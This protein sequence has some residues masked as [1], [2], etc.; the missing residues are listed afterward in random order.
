MLFRLLTALLIVEC[1]SEKAEVRVS[2]SASDT[3]PS[4]LM[5]HPRVAENCKE[6][7]DGNEGDVM[8]LVH[9]FCTV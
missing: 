4:T 7:F 1:S 5:T 2:N 6:N 8:F 3:S 9:Q